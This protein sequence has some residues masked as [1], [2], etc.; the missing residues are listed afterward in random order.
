MAPK[1]NRDS[2][3]ISI[4]ESVLIQPNGCP[5]EPAL[6]EVVPNGQQDVIGASSS[7]YSNSEDE[8]THIE[9][10]TPVSQ[11]FVCGDYDCIWIILLLEDILFLYRCIQ[12]LEWLSF[13]IS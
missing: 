4:G 8:Y 13:I 5:P 7:D 2:R 10:P 3:N 9:E 11:E 12:H 1:L 6:T